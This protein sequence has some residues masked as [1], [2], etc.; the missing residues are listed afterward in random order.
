MFEYIYSLDAFLLKQKGITEEDEIFSLFNEW[1][2]E[3]GF[4]LTYDEAVF[5]LGHIKMF[6]ETDRDSLI[7]AHKIDRRQLTQIKQKGV[8]KIERL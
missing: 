5:L 2:G 3:T 7:A 1:I 8:V 4:Y 6:F